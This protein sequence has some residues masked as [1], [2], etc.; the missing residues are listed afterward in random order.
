M[1][2]TRKSHHARNT[3]EVCMNSRKLTVLTLSWVTWITLLTVTHP[4]LLD[5]LDSPNGS[6]TR[7][8]A[9]CVCGGSVWMYTLQETDIA[10]VVIVEQLGLLSKSV[11]RV[12]TLPSYGVQPYALTYIYIPLVIY[13]RLAVQMMAG[14]VFILQ[15]KWWQ[16]KRWTLKN[17]KMNTVIKDGSLCEHKETLLYSLNLTRFTHTVLTERRWAWVARTSGR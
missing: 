10:C 12:L 9:C 14:E 11:L 16:E 7:E 8:V 3:T 17:E 5:S 4:Y 15:Y 13:I 6:E 1:S 2:T